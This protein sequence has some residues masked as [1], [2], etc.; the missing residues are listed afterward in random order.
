MESVLDLQPHDLFVALQDLHDRGILDADATRMHCRHPLLAHLATQH[1]SPGILQL[2]H[3]PH[4][5]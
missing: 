2:L 5:G 4:C 3:Q 1:A